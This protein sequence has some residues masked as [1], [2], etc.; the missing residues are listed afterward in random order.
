MGSQLSVYYTR[1]YPFSYP[2]RVHDGFYPRVPVGMD[3]FAIP[4]PKR[5]L[6]RKHEELCSQ[7]DTPFD[8]KYKHITKHMSFKHQTIFD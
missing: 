7:R 8:L 4:R 5:I 2:L 1:E 3:I 6:W